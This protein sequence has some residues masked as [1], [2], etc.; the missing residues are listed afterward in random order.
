MGRIT[1]L[2][3]CLLMISSA[4]AFQKSTF[5][6]GKYNCFVFVSNRPIL[7]DVL[8]FSSNGSY[9][10]R[11]GGSKSGSYKNMGTKL[12]LSGG[13]IDGAEIGLEADNRLRVLHKEN[14]GSSNPKWSS[15][16]CS[17]AK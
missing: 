16:Y 4:G 11:G 8:N 15:L 3:I 12:L 10:T 1:G 17:L 9:T 13:P 5:T 7:A 6:P 14:K 2:G